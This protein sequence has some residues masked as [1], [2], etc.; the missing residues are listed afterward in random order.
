MTIREF[1]E[2]LLF[3]ES[4]EEKLIAPPRGPVV[5]TDE[6]RGPAL[7]TP[8]APGRPRELRWTTAG[9]DRAEFPR[10]HQLGDAQARG[11]LLHFLAN[12]ELLATEL[13]ALAL[14]KFPDAPPAFRRGLLRTLEEEQFHSRWY[15]ARMAEYGVSFGE[16]PVNGF[17][18]NAVADMETPLD[19]VSRLPLT[20][21]QANLDFSLHYRDV[22]A[23]AGDAATASLLQRIHDDEIGHVGYG[24][25]WFRKWKDPQEDDW[26][27]HVRRLVFPLSPIRAKGKRLLDR[28]GRRRAGLDED[29]LRSLELCAGSRGRTPEV[30]LFNPEAESDLLGLP[31]DRPTRCL[32]EDLDVLPAFLARAEDVVLVRRPPRPEHLERWQRA[33][34]VWPELEPLTAEGGLHPDSLLPQRKLAGLRPWAW[35]PGVEASLRP[36]RAHINGPGT[37]AGWRET[38]R[39]L[40][41]KTTAVELR[42]AL[43]EPAALTGESVT[44]LDELHRA[45]DALRRAGHAHGVIKPAF[46]SSGRGFRRVERWTAADAPWAE[47][48]L[49]HHGALVVEPWLDRV[50]DFSAQLEMTTDGTLRLKGFTRLDTDARGRF[51]ACEATGRFAK[52][53]PPDLARFFSGDGRGAWVHDYYEQRVFPWL[54]TRFRA[55]GFVGACGID[56]FLYR[57]TEAGPGDDATPLRLRAVVELNPR[58]TMGRVA[59][60]LRRLAHPSARVRFHLASLAE[61]RA[62]GCSDLAAYARHLEH[63]DPWRLSTRQ[64]ITRLEHGTLVLNDPLRAQRFLGV[65]R[66]T[67]G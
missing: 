1:A 31:P 9:G 37:Q 34:F 25:N 13:M 24:L 26:S 50:A 55:A 27:A 58:F 4:L 64:D 15:L 52:L 59:W 54:A 35:T 18:W 14:L 19:Y 43:G 17:F 5:L 61:A 38:L 60:E 63:T 56:A 2:R 29:Y 8:P 42:R 47:Q 30:F 3:A 40:F 39:P 23:R 51:L 20:F 65:L 10:E 22:F 49:A 48:T 11:H 62:A 28:D 32:R 41:S 44:T 36:L 57:A 66:V 16:L 7:V 33:G 46:G 6:S 53:F 45:M 21:E 67:R 12:H